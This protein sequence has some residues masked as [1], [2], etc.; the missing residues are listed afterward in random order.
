MESSAKA[1]GDGQRAEDG[2]R[3][4]VANLSPADLER[5]SAYYGPEVYSMVEDERH[6]EIIERNSAIRVDVT[7]LSLPGGDI[8]V[9]V[10]GKGDDIVTLKFL[11]YTLSKLDLLHSFEC[12]F[13]TPV[14]VV[15]A[16]DKNTEEGRSTVRIDN[17]K[18]IQCKQYK[19][20]QP[21]ILLLKFFLQLRNL[22]D[23]YIGGI[24]SYLLYCM[25]LS[26]LQMHD[27]TCRKS[28]DEENTLAT[29]FVDFFYYWG[30]VRDYSQF[31]TTVR[32]LGHVYPRT[33]MQ[34]KDTSMLSC[35]SPLDPSIDIGKNAFNMSCACTA[36][37]QAFFILRDKETVTDSRQR[38]DY[39][40]EAGGDCILESLYDPSHPIFQHRAKSRLTY[41]ISKGYQY[42]KFSNFDDSLRRVCSQLREIVRDT[43]EGSVF[44]AQKKLMGSISQKDDA[45]PNDGTSS[46]VPF[47][48]ISEAITNEFYSND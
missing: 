9:C 37:K 22:N 5:L 10:E 16:I 40:F 14:P 46:E 13:N 27:A 2:E 48:V 34:S 44:N 30:F 1:E 35:E 45:A 33:L 36:F 25:V 21:L 39:K 43:D 41:P 7:G 11:V 31:V 28:S 12:V 32:G 18:N 4:I 8:D 42:Q 17:H 15:K 20:M 23:T 38:D 6:Q 24:G 47:Y 3:G 29:M 26:F 19:Y